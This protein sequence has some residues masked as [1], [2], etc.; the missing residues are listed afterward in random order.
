MWFQSNKEWK[1]PQDMLD[2]E[3]HVLRRDHISNKKFYENR[4][5]LGYHSAFFFF[6]RIFRAIEVNSPE[7]FVG[8]APPH[9]DETHDRQ[10]F[11]GDG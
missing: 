2:L 7:S 11:S 9:T 4:V 1:L 8:E 5:S 10:E 6:A 3:T